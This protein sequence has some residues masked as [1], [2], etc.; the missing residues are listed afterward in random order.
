[1][2]TRASPLSRMSACSWR[3]AS[4]NSCRARAPHPP[5]LSAAGRA[6]QKASPAG[7]ARQNATLGRTRGTVP[8]L[9][10]A[11]CPSRDRGPALRCT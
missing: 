9:C 8:Q 10:A 6:Q 2:S 3:K 11:P 7:R 5:R 1:M 4:A